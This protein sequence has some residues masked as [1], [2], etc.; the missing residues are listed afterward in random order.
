[1]CHDSAGMGISYS[2]TMGCSPV[3]GDNQRALVSG[4]SY[5]Q[6]DKHGITIYTTYICVDI[7]HHEIFRAKVGKGGISFSIQ[8]RPIITHLTLCILMDYSF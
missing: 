6:V 7:A 8:D 1:M 3:R 5:G 4:L 2:Y